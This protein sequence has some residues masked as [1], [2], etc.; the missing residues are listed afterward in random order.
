MRFGAGGSS[1][2]KEVIRAEGAEG[3]GG[4]GGGCIDLG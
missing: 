4:G 2:A 3:R 1:L